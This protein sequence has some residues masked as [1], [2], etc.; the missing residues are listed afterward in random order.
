MVDDAAGFDGIQTRNGLQ[1]LALAGTGDARNAQ[2]L[3]GVHGEADIVQTLHAQL[4][5]HG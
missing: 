2:H 5:E 4:V 1:Q 3:A